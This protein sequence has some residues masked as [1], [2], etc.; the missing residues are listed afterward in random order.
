MLGRV[1][2]ES[3]TGDLEQCPPL[4]HL[5]IPS[6]EIGPVRA[7]RITRVLGQC[8]AL[9]HLDHYVNDIG[10]TGTE[11]ISGVLPRVTSKRVKEVVEKRE[12]H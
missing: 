2:T 11:S 6:N 1:V 7:K 4:T 8:T 10:D 3:L 5:N 12:S 9:D